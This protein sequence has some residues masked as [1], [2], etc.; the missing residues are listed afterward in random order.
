MVGLLRSMKTKHGTRSP[1]R[2]SDLVL[3]MN[4]DLHLKFSLNLITY[5]KHH[6]LQ[7]HRL[8]D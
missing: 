5:L 1:S 8:I 4:P 7:L 3:K 2:R 6:A